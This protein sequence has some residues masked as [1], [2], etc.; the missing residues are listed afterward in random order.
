MSRSK[1]Q[2]ILTLN[3]QWMKQLRNWSWQLKRKTANKR[4][5][6]EK[7]STIWIPKT[8][9]ALLKNQC[10]QTN[11]SWK[12]RL[13]RTSERATC[14]RIPSFRSCRGESRNQ[15]EQ[16]TYRPQQ[17]TWLT[18]KICKLLSISKKCQW[19][20][21]QTL[22]QTSMKTSLVCW[23]SRQSRVNWEALF[24]QLSHPRICCCL[25]LFKSME[26]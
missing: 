25:M 2:T 21:S 14:W 23:L 9:K 4:S 20:W 12:Q 6:K 22:L 18:A 16:E 3:N 17:W 5:P 8:R 19:K 26:T 24:Y 10:F 15:R 11:L 7:M 13:A 1:V